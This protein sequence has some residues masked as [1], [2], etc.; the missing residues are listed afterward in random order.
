M[1]VNFARR[2]TCRIRR[3]ADGADIGRAQFEPVAGVDLDGIHEPPA[4]ELGAGDQRRRRPD[5]LLQQVQTIDRRLVIRSV[6]ITRKCVGRVKEP[7][8]EPLAAAVRLQDEGV[9]GAFARRRDEQLLAGNENGI[10]RANAGG[11]EGGVLACL[12]DFEIEGAAA[13]DDAAPVPFEPGQHRGRQFGGV[14]VIA[15]MRGGAHPVVVDTLRR[16]L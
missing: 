10:G 14:A 8:A 9:C 16:R 3:I 1:I 6:E 7:H 15:R 13:V 11:F 4:D 5:V 2:L 12:A